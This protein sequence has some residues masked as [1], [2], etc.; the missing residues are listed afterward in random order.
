MTNLRKQE[1]SNAV[2]LFFIYFTFLFSKYTDWRRG[3]ALL[4]VDV[5]SG[6]LTCF[7]KI[8]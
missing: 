1:K 5:Y 3:D 2:F 8:S 6:K 4:I 7:I